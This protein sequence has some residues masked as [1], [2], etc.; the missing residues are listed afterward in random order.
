MV[1]NNRKLPNG[2]ASGYDHWLQLSRT[3]VSV[4]IYE[5]NILPFFLRT[6]HTVIFACCEGNRGRNKNVLYLI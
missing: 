1:E 6:L 2:D 4:S 3:I 5:D